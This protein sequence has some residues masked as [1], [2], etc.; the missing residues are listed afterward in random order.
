MAVM[1]RFCVIS[2][3][4]GTGKTTTVMKILALLNEQARGRKLAVGLA[5]PTGKA[6]ARMQSAMIAALQ[7]PEF[8]LA[9]RA[10]IPPEACTLHRLLGARPHTI[11]YRHNRDN[12]LPLD[13]LV[14][15]EASMADLALAAKLL[16]ALPV[17]ARLILLGDKD[18]LASV[19]AGAVLGDICARPGLSAGFAKRLAAASGLKVKDLAVAKNASALSDSVALLTRS[20]R[21]GPESGIGTLARLVNAGQGSDALALLKSGAHADLAWRTVSPADLRSALRAAVGD[22]L[23]AYFDTVRSG[24]EP[25]EIFERFND[26]RILCARRTGLLGV[27]GV[28]RLIEEALEER[29]VIGTRSPWY[30]GRPVMITRNDY[31]LRVFNG[32][33]GI[34]LPDPQAE[35]QLKIFFPAGAEGARGVR[36][37]APARLPDHET[38]YAMTIHK[39]QGSEFGRV[40]MV[41]PSEPSPIMSRELVYTGITRAAKCVDIWGNEET[42]SGAVAKRLSRSGG[43]RDRLW[44]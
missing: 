37:I 11:D 21:F 5:A 31:N 42:F 4:P 44:R 26:F 35:G 40:L 12:P 9:M 27:V 33:V 17:R 43:L 30:P 8:D 23:R 22:H 3:G 34:A 6:A 32:D 25:G 20:Y 29:R 15:D 36:K 2:G 28:N 38:A 10:T 1:R 39:S 41:L 19:E 24:R 18:Q 14:V 7:R 16:E 13:V